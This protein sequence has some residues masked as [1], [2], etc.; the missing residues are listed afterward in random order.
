MEQAKTHDILKIK[1][2]NNNE[3]KIINNIKKNINK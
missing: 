1:L 3:I 2:K